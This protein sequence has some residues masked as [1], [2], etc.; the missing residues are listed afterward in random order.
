M[1][2]SQGMIERLQYHDS[3][4]APEVGRKGCR[5]GRHLAGCRAV[6]LDVADSQYRDICL[7]SVAR[8]AINTNHPG[9][10]EVDT[11]AHRYTDT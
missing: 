6:R 10:T 8:R 9:V 4:C 5:S 2:K 1:I 7:L 11:P 3:D